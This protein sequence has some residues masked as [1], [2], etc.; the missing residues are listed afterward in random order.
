M[1]INH[2]MGLNFTPE[3]GGGGTPFLSRY[4]VNG[5][6]IWATDEDGSGY[7]DDNS[8]LICV[9]AR[10]GDT[11]SEHLFARSSETNPG[12]AGAINAIRDAMTFAQGLDAAKAV[13][14]GLSIEVSAFYRTGDK[15]GPLITGC[16]AFPEKAEGFGVYI[17]NPL[18]SHVQ[19]FDI[20]AWLDKSEE[21]RALTLSAAFAYADHLAEHLGCKV[22]SQLARPA[23]PSEPIP[24]ADLLH[25]AACLWEEAQKIQGT[26]AD[27]NN[28]PLPHTPQ[29]MADFLREWDDMGSVHM[30][31]MV[32]GWAE[33]C[34]RDWKRAT[35][36]GEFD[37]CFDWQW[38]PA[39]MSRKLAAVYP[40]SERVTVDVPSDG[41]RMIAGDIYAGETAH[42][43][44]IP[45][46]AYPAEE[47]KPGYEAADI[48]GDV[49]GALWDRINCLVAPFSGTYTGMLGEARY[50]SISGRPETIEVTDSYGK[51]WTVTVE[52]A[53]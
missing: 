34:E 38:V 36:V 13:A 43:M 14:A 8:W 26:F 18:A 30:R 37:S 12:P 2:L 6:A 50:E 16:N 4:L 51:K 47:A 42:G 15:N 11:M 25:A 39:W 19:D 49:Q 5:T 35:D 10:E 53:N 33:E 32:T 45:L 1:I 40:V 48:A 9:Y 31:F 20:P 28:A 21:A 17:R 44:P 27:A 52:E 29:W 23:A 22:D 46:Y 24:A 7:P 41:R 3:I